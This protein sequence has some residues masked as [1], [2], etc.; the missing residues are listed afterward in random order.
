MKN[1]LFFSFILNF[2]LGYSQCTK[3]DCVQ[4]NRSL[5]MKMVVFMKEVG[6]KEKEMEK[7]H[8]LVKYVKLLILGYGK[9][10]GNGKGTKT[11]KSGS[12]LGQWL[13]GKKMDT[14]L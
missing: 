12:A 6:L 7:E 9:K 13:D 8:I 10:S 11:W 5:H 2:C 4:G 3:G 14:D 1:L